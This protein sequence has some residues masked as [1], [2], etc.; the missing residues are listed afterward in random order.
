VGGRT[1]DQRVNDDEDSDNGMAVALALGL[2]VV[3]GG[4]FVRRMVETDRAT[5]PPRH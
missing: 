1:A 5:V 3:V 2:H 4:L